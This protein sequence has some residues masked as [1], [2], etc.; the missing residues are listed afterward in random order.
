[1]HQFKV[2]FQLMYIQFTEMLADC[3]NVSNQPCV[4]ELPEDD[5]ILF[6]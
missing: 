3:L 5:L 1:M 2:N 6:I 4:T